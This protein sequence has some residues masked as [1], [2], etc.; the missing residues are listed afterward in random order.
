MSVLDIMGNTWSVSEDGIVE[1]RPAKEAGAAAPP[2]VVIPVPTP[3][4][5]AV[6]V[7]CCFGGYV[8]ALAQGQL[9]RLNPRGPGYSDNGMAKRDAPGEAPIDCVGPYT[10]DGTEHTKWHPVALPRAA[11]ALES[12]T[13]TS[14]DVIVTL[15]GVGA[16]DA[17]VVVE[18]RKTVS[19]G[20]D[21]VSVTLRTPALPDPRGWKTLS[22]VM[23]CSNHDIQGAVI[24][25]YIY[26]VGGAIWYRGF[27][28]RE[29]MFNEIWRFDTRRAHSA[30]RGSDGAAS[31]RAWEVV[32][33]TPEPIA[34]AGVVA[35]AGKLYIM[36]GCQNHNDVPNDRSTHGQLWCFDPETRTTVAN[37]D[38]AAAGGA[39]QLPDM[40]VPRQEC[41]GAV[42]NG[43]IYAFGWDTS[44][45]SWSPGESQWR[46]EASCPIT[47]GGADGMSGQFNCTVLDNVAYFAGPFGLLS[48]SPSAGWNTTTLAPSPTAGACP[49]VAAH[50]GEIWVMSGFFYDAT[51]G[52]MCELQPAV[53]S[54]APGKGTWTLRPP[55]PCT[56]AWGA[57]VSVDGT[58][59][60]IGG[61]KFSRNAR[62]FCF[63]NRVFA[64]S[65]Q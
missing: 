61:S 59:Y 32:G 48:F 18:E 36:G 62:T 57:G 24:G 29:H 23:P 26:I 4:T 55:L 39:V 46:A 64:L 27:P 50:A 1:V 11:T 33:H 9:F 7:A 20:A 40:L 34:F 21:G 19:V 54:F 28:A 51:P 49:L 65:G 58:L 8:W 35:L 22:S 12:P 37:G 43:R 53:H 2:N 14:D 63:D 47:M 56:E 52:K 44:C 60:A 31:G 10:G 42:L 3:V 15:A 6:T 5:P 30:P 38:A 25:P 17:V 41:C 16:G 45:E 13:S